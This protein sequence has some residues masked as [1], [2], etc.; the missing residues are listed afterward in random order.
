MRFGL[1]RK[2]GGQIEISQ[3]PLDD[4]EDVCLAGVDRGSE[5]SIESSGMRDLL[6]AETGA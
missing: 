3:L 2:K 4:P 1:S 5:Y 6:T